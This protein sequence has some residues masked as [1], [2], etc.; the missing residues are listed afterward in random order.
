MLEMFGYM[1]VLY[2]FVGVFASGVDITYG[3]VTGLEYIFYPFS[4]ETG[5]FA[6]MS[7][8]CNITISLVTIVLFLKRC[9]QHISMMCYEYKN[10][11]R[12]KLLYSQKRDLYKCVIAIVGAKIIVD[13]ISMIGVQ[14]FS[15]ETFVHLTLSYTL[16][17]ILWIDAL[18]VIR[19]YKINSNVA[20][21]VM[22]VGV[23]ISI[24]I[25][26]YLKLTFFAYCASTN[27]IYDYIVKGI[28]IIV[29]QVMEIYMIK[30]ADLY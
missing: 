9:D 10:N 24:L 28:L 29:L 27:Y 7:M 12:Y 11:N 17:S 1:L 26:K 8:I 13:F 14:V 3:Q 18:Y 20:F 23:L 16:T 19:L 15:I 2:L 4:N 6:L 25:Q 5:K 21:F 22:M 30:N